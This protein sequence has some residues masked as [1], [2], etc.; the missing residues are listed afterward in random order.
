MLTRRFHNFRNL[1]SPSPMPFISECPRHLVRAPTVSDPFGLAGL[2][3]STAF[4]RVPVASLLLA[5]ISMCAKLLN[6]RGQGG[7]SGV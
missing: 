2:A 5:I 3:A 7:G 4:A 1:Q 6:R